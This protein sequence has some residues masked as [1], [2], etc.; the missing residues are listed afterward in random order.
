M[1]LFLSFFIGIFL[2]VNLV[3]CSQ[4]KTKTIEDEAKSLIGEVEKLPQ[5]TNS[6]KKIFPIESA[7]VKYIN[8]VAGQEMTR[9]WWFDDYGNRQLED[10]YMT[11][12][13]NKTGGKALVLDGYRYNWE[14]DQSEGTRMKFYSAAAT[15][16]ENVSQKD[17]ERYGIEKHG[18]EEIAGKRCLKVTLEKP[19][20]STVWVWEGIPLKTVSNFAG[21]DVVMEAVEIKTGGVDASLFQ[22]PGGITFTD[23]E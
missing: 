13:G 4:K 15:D 9:E 14:Y 22:I 18:Y 1:K 21:Q 6:I 2:F 7:W 11:I 17:K 12:M 16:Y 8:Q 3:S 19:V 5:G 20:K 23:Y 10:N